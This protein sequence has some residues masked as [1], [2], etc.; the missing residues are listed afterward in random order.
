MAAPDTLAELQAA[1]I[2]FRDERDWAQFH[3]P[4]DLALGLS[5][6]AGELAELFLWK[7]PAQTEAELR[8]NPALRQRLAEEL[9]DVQI[10]LLYLAHA[11]GLDL[12]TAVRAKLVRNAEK[13]PVDKAR[14]NSTKYTEL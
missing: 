10:F 14:G 3:T 9:A 6:E 7:T 1:A 13:Y 4:K 12:G 2:R 11:G 5:I 8:G